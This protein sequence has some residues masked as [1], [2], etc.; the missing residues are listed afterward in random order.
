MAI[1]AVSGVPS[2][3][4]VAATR[5]VGPAFGAM[6]PAFA[7]VQAAANVRGREDGGA[8]GE[9]GGEAADAGLRDEAGEATK[10]GLEPNGY[11]QL[12][13]RE[14]ERRLAELQAEK[15]R[16]ER[17]DSDLANMKSL[18]TARV[19]DQ[20]R[21]RD[22]H[23]RSHEAA[24]IGAGGR[25]VRGGASFSYQTG[26]DGRQYAVGGEVGI[27][28]SPIPGKPAETAEKMRVVRA[29]A[30]APS[31]PSAADLSVA[32]AAANAEAE[33]LAELAATRMEAAAKSYA[34]EHDRGTRPAPAAAGEGAARTS[35]EATA[36]QVPGAPG[37][38]AAAGATVAAAG[39][40]AGSAG[41]AAGAEGKGAF[42]ASGP[43]SLAEPPAYYWPGDL[44]D[45]VA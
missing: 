9:A 20:L 35:T 38:G 25:Y 17:K 44:V 1:Q 29:A 15:A 5:R 27:D 34:T 19:L 21:S 22:A 28:T 7:R 33:A 30:L 14:L 6:D 42:P 45:L 13:T 26:P 12:S 43:A 40:A 36:G 24:H 3:S 2:A 32:A 23:V 37:Q 8:R 16:G 11:G 41:A 31:D 39:T 4:P 10:R 18:E